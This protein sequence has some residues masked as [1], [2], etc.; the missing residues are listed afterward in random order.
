MLS[1]L[2]TVHNPM[3]NLGTTNLWLYLFP[4]IKPQKRLAIF[5]QICI[6]LYTL[7]YSAFTLSGFTVILIYELNFDPAKCGKLTNDFIISGSLTLW[8]KHPM[9]S[10]E[11]FEYIKLLT[12]ME[13]VEY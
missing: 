13:N 10:N 4:Q 1:C 8:M 3:T 5:K 2:S 6:F 7:R 11:L 9:S 12:D